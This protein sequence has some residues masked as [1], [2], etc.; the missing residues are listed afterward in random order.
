MNSFWNIAEKYPPILVR[1]LAR[2]K[3]GPPLTTAE[4]AERAV[5]HWYEHGGDPR[6][7]LNKPYSSYVINSISQELSW[8]NIEFGAMRAFLFACD[9]DFCDRDDMNRKT[10]YLRSVKHRFGYLSQSPEFLTVLRPL[11]LRYREH[12]KSKL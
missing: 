2:R 1:L 3:N 10:A 11:A 7:L 12:I 9:M 6:L 5:K 8:N 4:I